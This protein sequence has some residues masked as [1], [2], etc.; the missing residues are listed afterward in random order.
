M[1]QKRILII[2]TFPIVS[3]LTG[4]QKRQEAIVQAYA[5]AGYKVQYV[6]IYFKEHHKQAAVTDIELPPELHE[7]MRQSPHTGDI[8][9]GEAIYDNPTVKRKMTAMLLSFRP[10]II[11]IEQVFPYLGMQR[12]L[13]EMNMQ[14]KLLFSSH[15]VEAP[16][17]RKILESTG[18]REDEIAPV[19]DKIHKAELELTKASE[20]V[21]A[22]TDADRRYYEKHGAKRTVTARNGMARIKTTEAAK[23]AWRQQYA[24]Q[25]IAKTALFVGAAHPPNWVGFLEMIGTGMGF[26]P[27]DSRLVLAGG[28]CDYFEQTINEPYNYFHLTFWQRVLAAGRPSDE[29]LG[30]LLM[31]ADVIV[32]PITEGGGSNLKTAEAVL[33]GRPV[34]GTSHAF[35]SFE[36]LKDLPNIYIADK[37]EAFRQAI[38]HAMQAPLQKR[39]AAQVDLAESVLWERCLM[40]AIE[41][42]RTV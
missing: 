2:N 27:F 13:A 23:E 24:K 30:A 31:L 20:L 28:I 14:P 29:S 25:G 17:K 8:V 11:Q 39:T 37:P 7:T 18:M 32:L 6:G 40:P 35:R 38:V 15:N 19:V 9:S 22:C 4:G 34:V 10:D 36:E 21:I 16:H 42:V 12:L 1:A 33:S 41:E 5:A 3:A 26:M